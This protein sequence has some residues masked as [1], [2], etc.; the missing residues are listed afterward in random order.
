[1]DSKIIDAA[2]MEVYEETYTGTGMLI[3]L[4][5]AHYAATLSLVS[6]AVV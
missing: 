1:M 5:L 4:F 6:A 2:E 3:Y